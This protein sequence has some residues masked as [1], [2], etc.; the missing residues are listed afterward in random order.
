MVRKSLSLKNKNIVVTGG[1]G[2]IGQALVAQLK[3]DGARVFVLDEKTG[4]NIRDW[5][6]LSS[7]KKLKSINYLYHLAAVTYTPFSW[8]NP[9][10]TIEN[11][12]MSTLNVLE[13]CKLKSIKKIIYVS[14]YVY[15]FPKY[16]PIDEKHPTNPVNPYS[17]SKLICENLC[18]AYSETFGLLCV[19]LRPFNVYGPNQ[20]PNFLVSSI[21]KQV[22]EN[23]KVVL[24]DPRPKRDF[25]FVTDMV[26]ALILAGEHSD[27]K[28]DVF[29]IGLGKSYSIN[30]IV[31]KLAK[32]F[33]RPIRVAFK[34]KRR[35]NEILDVVADISKARAKL[36]WKPKISMD[37]G[38]SRCI[39]NN[40]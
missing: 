28:F 9:R 31:K 1:S 6:K 35:K 7:F 12:I 36:G 15:G 5:K 24:D 13:F 19:I 23:K 22:R 11:N 8:K 26:D 20:S 16:L 29:N 40:L 37:E 10:E 34:M 38:L 25:L 2:F 39:L 27:A 18:K 14:S 3:K 4:C 33:D 30:D 21:I 17:W 32:A